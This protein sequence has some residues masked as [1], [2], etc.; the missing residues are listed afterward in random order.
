[1]YMYEVGRFPP[2]TPPPPTIGYCTSEE[3]YSTL[4]MSYVGQARWGWWWCPPPGR[5]YGSP[6]GFVCMLCTTAHL[7]EGN[8]PSW[9][10]V[11][12]RVNHRPR[13]FVSFSP[14]PSARLFT[15]LYERFFLL[16]RARSS[17]SL[18]L[19]SIDYDD[20]D[21]DDDVIILLR[22]VTP[23]PLRFFFF[24]SDSCPRVMFGMSNSTPPC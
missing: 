8:A 9:P 4:C 7:A 20:G 17:S 10:W 18:S 19:A 21:D 22:F 5:A 3:M 15:C 1:M 12:S 2:C 13:S 11:A 23:P 24:S 14:L 16:P 6:T